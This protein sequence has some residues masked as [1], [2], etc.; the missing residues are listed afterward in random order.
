MTIDCVHL[1]NIQGSVCCKQRNEDRETKGQRDMFGGNSVEA[2]SFAGQETQRHDADAKIQN[3]R[4]YAS[5]LTSSQKDGT[6]NAWHGKEK[7]PK[8]M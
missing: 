1:A 2:V 7:N 6:R 5:S 4:G 8:P 3:K